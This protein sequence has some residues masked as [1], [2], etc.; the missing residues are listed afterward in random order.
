M[1]HCIIINHLLQQRID[2]KADRLSRQHKVY[3]SNGSNNSS[4]SSSGWIDSLLRTGVEDNRKNLIFWVLTPY[5]ITIRGLDPDRAYP[6]LES[7]LYKCAE[8]RRLEP[9]WNSFRYRIRY[10]LDVAENQER[11]PIRFETF[12][13]YYPDIYREVLSARSQTS[14]TSPSKDYD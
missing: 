1:V 12:K 9:D 8:V 14:Q 13:E 3:Y 7:W 4:S 5:L 10:C 6:I 11:K 2:E